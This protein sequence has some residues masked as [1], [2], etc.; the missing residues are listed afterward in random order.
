MLVNLLQPCG[1]IPYCSHYKPIVN[2]FIYTIIQTWLWLD[3]QLRLVIPAPPRF[4]DGHDVRAVTS[5]LVVIAGFLAV[6][7][8]PLLSCTSIFND[9]LLFEGIQDVLSFGEGGEQTVCGSW[10]ALPRILIMDARLVVQL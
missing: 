3:Y 10:S 2:N 5:L 9:S 7:T 6:P 8:Y 4:P 1:N